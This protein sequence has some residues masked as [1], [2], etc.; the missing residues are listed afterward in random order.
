MISG[1]YKILNTKNNK[2]YIGSA[3]RLTTRFNTHRSK[4][5]LNYHPNKHLQAAYNKYSG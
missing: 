5:K 2:C 3:V 1:I 4:L